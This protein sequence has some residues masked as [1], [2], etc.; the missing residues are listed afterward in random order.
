VVISEELQLRPAQSI[1]TF[2]S[3]HPDANHIN[4]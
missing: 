3:P 4:A 2:V 1:G